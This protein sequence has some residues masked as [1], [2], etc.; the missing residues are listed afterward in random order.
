MESVQRYDPATPLGPFLAAN[1]RKTSPKTLLRA[2]GLRPGL[3]RG[4]WRCHAAGFSKHRQSVT[5]GGMNDKQLLWPCVWVG[6]IAQSA[7]QAG[8][9]RCWAASVES[10]A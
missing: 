6:D 9:E 2:P 5:S 8:D 10:L 7:Q 4:L 3:R 1:P